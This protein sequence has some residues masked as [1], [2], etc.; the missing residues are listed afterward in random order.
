MEPC[1]RKFY[2]S[3]TSALTGESIPREVN[4]WRQVLSGSTINQ[5]GF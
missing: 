2:V 4:D 3:D 1:R 5:N